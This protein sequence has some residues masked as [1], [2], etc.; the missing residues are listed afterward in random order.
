MVN[1]QFNKECRTPKPISADTILRF[2]LFDSDKPNKPDEV[3]TTRVKIT[4]LILNDKIN[5]KEMFAIEGE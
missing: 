5:R 1:K 4:D 2:E 3:G